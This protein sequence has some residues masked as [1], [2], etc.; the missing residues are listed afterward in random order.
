MD[1][2]RIEPTNEAAQSATGSQMTLSKKTDGAA[3]HLVETG[4]FNNT[5]VAI[6]RLYPFSVISIDDRLLKDLQ[7]VNEIKV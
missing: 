4:K 6:K 3:H 7:T 5:L 1:W 2:D